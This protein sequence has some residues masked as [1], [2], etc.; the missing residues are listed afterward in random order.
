MREK[1]ERERKRER[2]KRI[3]MVE[4]EKLPVVASGNCKRFKHTHVCIYTM[5]IISDEQ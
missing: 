2:G 1:T 3:K 4:I 5:V